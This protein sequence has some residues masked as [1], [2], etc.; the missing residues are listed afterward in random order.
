M[1]EGVPW[2][3]VSQS[4]GS[5]VFSKVLTKEKIQ[6]NKNLSFQRSLC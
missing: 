5:T 4:R 2:I 1:N 3:E 6:F